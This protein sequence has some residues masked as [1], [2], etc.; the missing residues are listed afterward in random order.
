MSR[1]GRQGKR[2]ARLSAGEGLSFSSLSPRGQLPCPCEEH[3]QV[4]RLI[5]L[6]LEK[7]PRRFVLLSC[8][9]DCLKCFSEAEVSWDDSALHQLAQQ[10]HRVA[11]VLVAP[12]GRGH[13][14][15]RPPPLPSGTL[16]RPWHQLLASSAQTCPRSYPPPHASADAAESTRKAASAPPPG[17]QR[18][19]S[20]QRGAWD[21]VQ[22][23]YEDFNSRRV[24]KG[25]G[26]RLFHSKRVSSRPNRAAEGPQELLW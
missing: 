19:P 21:V 3:I 22:R 23:F 14:A 18:R 2:P 4:F 16:Q 15:H 11:T 12:F 1:A 8:T 6:V 13:L 17:V 25:E 9:D 7:N 26:A 24:N 5:G 10:A 20:A